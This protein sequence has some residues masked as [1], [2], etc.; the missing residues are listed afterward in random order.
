[1]ECF[2]ACH[3][4]CFRLLGVLIDHKLTMDD[5]TLRN[6]KKSLTKH[7]GYTKD[8][9]FYDTAGFI[10]QFKS[11]VLCLLEQSAVTSY[12][13]AQSHFEVQNGLQRNFV[14]E[15]GL[16]EAETFLVHKLAPPA[17]M[18]EI[19]ALG[20][21]HKIQLGETHPDFSR[22]FPQ[23]INAAPDR[24]RHPMWRHGWQF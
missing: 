9:G 7:P 4:R 12:H 21:L 8:A 22:W 13:A 5:D 23:R 3:R 20:L 18:R 1:M 16:S 10:Q 14:C 11:N 17:L 15:L 2:S 19:A 24:K 6:R